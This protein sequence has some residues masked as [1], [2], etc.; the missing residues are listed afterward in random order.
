MQLRSGLTLKGVEKTYDNFTR[1]CFKL[2]PKIRR[3]HYLFDESYLTLQNLVL[4]IS[5]YGRIEVLKCLLDLGFSTERVDY[6]GS[7]PLMIS[8]MCGWN[9]CTRLLIERG[10]NVYAVNNNG[11]SVRQI[12]QR[13]SRFDTV[14][15][16]IMRR[17]WNV[18][19]AAVKFLG[20]HSRAVVTANHPSRIDFTVRD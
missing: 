19:R 17:R 8:I 20:L 14:K 2:N 12:E 1:E 15:D 13:Y 11:F 3:I 7:T 5:L 4:S 6:N 16:T 10:A 18:I 9:V